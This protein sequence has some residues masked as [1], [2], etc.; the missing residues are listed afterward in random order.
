MIITSKENEI[1]KNI[2]KL[3]DKKYREKYNKYIIEGINLIKEAIIEKINIE[4][5]VVCDEYL[6]QNNN[7]ENQETIK[8]NN[9]FLEKITNKKYNLIYVDKKVF[10]LLTEVKTPQGIIAVIEKIKSNN[11]INYSEDLI[12]ILENIQ[13]P[14][15]LG[16]IIRTID[17]TGLSQIIVS[18]NT[19][20]LFNSK[21][22][23]ATMGSIF[24]VNII[25]SDDILKTIEEIKQNKF[26]IYGAIIG[27]KKNIYEVKYKKVAVV[28]GNEAKGISKDVLNIL[29]EKI[30][31][32]MRR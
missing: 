10:D 5:I 20:D 23:R 31:I 15:N 8:F 1:I 12:L 19:A 2:K 13:D 16:T 14:G 27:G 18:K 24:R 7:M 11:I 3:K 17:S 25:I 4:T 28:I 30:T 26:K 21:V 32:P 6:K 9:N 22:I 29:D